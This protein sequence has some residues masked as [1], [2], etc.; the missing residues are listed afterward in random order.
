MDSTRAKGHNRPR[1]AAAISPISTSLSPPPRLFAMTDLSLPPPPLITQPARLPELTT[2]LRQAGRFA[3]DT[4]SNSLYAYH[5]QVCL[6]QISTAQQD[7]LIDTLALPDQSWLAALVADAGIEVTIHAAENDILLLHRDF[8]FTFGRVF[9]TLWAARILGWE[10]PGLAA[11]LQEQFGIG[12]DKGMQRTDWGRRPLSAR[13]C[14][15]ARLDTHFLLALR[16]HQE[17]ELRARGRWQ[18]AQETFAE[19][20]HIRWEEKEAPT[21][22][23]LPGVNDLAPREQGVLAALFAWREQAAA[24]RDLPP[25]KVL[26]N[27][28]L[29]E[30]A[31]TQPET[32]RALRAVRGVSTR[33]PRRTAQD[34]LAAI[35]QGRRA[36]PPAPPSRNHFAPRPDEQVLARFDRL[37]AWRTRTAQSR[38]VEPD[39]VLTNQVLMAI[40][41]ENPAHLSS[42]AAL[43]LFGPWKLQTYGAALLEVV[44]G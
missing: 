36:E 44:R 18:E 16:D 11:I 30:L 31:R 22:W 37:R 10:R 20:L 6:I 34:L 40:A 28:T 1:L 14:Q 19:L 21:F 39:V 12:L 27:E 17:Q 15:Y 25:F 42:L 4:E 43:N 38:G 13:Q 33:L 32:E 24:Q 2:A 26:Q 8:G 41:R 23:R 7:Y 29:L 35:E 9:D 3:L 5:Y